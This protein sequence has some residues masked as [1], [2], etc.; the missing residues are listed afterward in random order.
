M[1]L[2]RY[3]VY[4]P[5]LRTGWPEDLGVFRDP[6]PTAAERGVGLALKDNHTMTITTFSK[7]NYMVNKF[8][9]IILSILLILANRH[10]NNFTSNS[11]TPMFTHTCKCSFNSKKVTKCKS[12]RTWC[13]ILSVMVHL[14]YTKPFNQKNSSSKKSNNASIITPLFT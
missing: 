7:N 9:Y 4:K 6:I 8:C 1:G 5:G 12:E 3:N 14:V 13:G 2:S 10:Y 11:I